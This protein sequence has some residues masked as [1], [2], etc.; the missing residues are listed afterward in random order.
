[1]NISPEE[2]AFL[3]R[4][5]GIG[6]HIWQAHY[7]ASRATNSL[8]GYDVH[9]N[10]EADAIRHC[11]G[12]A[13]LTRELGPFPDGVATAKEFLDLHE[14]RPGNPPLEKIMDTHNNDV[15]MAIAQDFPPYDFEWSDEQLKSMCVAKLYNGELIRNLIEAG[16]KQRE[17]AWRRFPWGSS[18]SWSLR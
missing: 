18:W 7:K 15:G 17:E 8:F 3:E 13:L 4:N 5:R 11:Y 16:D 1:M 9:H 2:V 10:N 12:A 6:I 14:A